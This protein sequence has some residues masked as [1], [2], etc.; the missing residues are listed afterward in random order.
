MKKWLVVLF[1]GIMSSS[2]L[3][4]Q[5]GGGG[6][7]FPEAVKGPLTVTST[8]DVIDTKLNGVIY[9]WPSLREPRILT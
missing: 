9:H 6:P 4:V 2:A 7:E 3:A 1:L 5:L 8:I